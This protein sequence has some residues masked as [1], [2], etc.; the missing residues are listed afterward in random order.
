MR[1]ASSYWLLAPSLRLE[2]AQ[3]LRLEG[4]GGRRR[5]MTGEHKVR[6]YETPLFTR[7]I[8]SFQSRA[9]LTFALCSQPSALSA[10]QP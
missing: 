5:C 7:L 10:V 2:A 4:V 8:S 9:L 6:P 3:G 1:T